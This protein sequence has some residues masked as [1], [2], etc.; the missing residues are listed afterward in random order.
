[1]GA[2]LY[3]GGSLLVG[4][5][6]CLLSLDSLAGVTITHGRVNCC[7]GEDTAVGTPHLRAA[8]LVAGD[9]TDE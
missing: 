8:L 6:C 7:T 5:E 2:I 3:S 4:E 1:M 9:K